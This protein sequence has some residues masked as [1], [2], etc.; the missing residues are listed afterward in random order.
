MNWLV[1]EVV[2]D[3]VDITFARQDLLVI[4][5]VPDCFMKLLLFAYRRGGPQILMSVVVL[6]RYGS[7]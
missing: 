3:F 7:P 2:P 4:E 1:I 6:F 5:L